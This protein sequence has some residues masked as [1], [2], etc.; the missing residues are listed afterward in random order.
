MTPLC[1]RHA[2]GGH[3]KGPAGRGGGGL[4]KRFLQEASSGREL[5]GS[6]VLGRERVGVGVG[7]SGLRR[8]YSRRQEQQVQ[9]QGLERG[10][11]LFGDGERNRIGTRR[12]G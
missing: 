6:E 3:P 12:R 9:R 7:V 4:N 8:I 11:G 2:D 5:K 1:V 10:C